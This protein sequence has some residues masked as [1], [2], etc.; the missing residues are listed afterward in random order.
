ASPI[1]PP[2][3]PATATV[4]PLPAF[5]APSSIP[6]TSAPTPFTSTSARPVTRSSRRLN[7]DTP[8]V[9]KVPQ[10]IEISHNLLHISSASTQEAHIESSTKRM[11]ALE[12]DM[13]L[14]KEEV[15]NF[16]KQKG[17]R[18]KEEEVA[19]DNSQVEDIYKKLNSLDTRLGK[20]KTR[21]DYNMAI[22]N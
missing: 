17:K 9:G 7:L 16:A 5:S 4:T 19:M 18:K 6:P 20:S 12:A 3:V 1:S 22:F 11:E 8:A 2:Y 13:K 10:D 14:L 21:H 15:K